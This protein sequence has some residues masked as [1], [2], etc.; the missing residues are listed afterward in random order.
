MF[1]IAVLVAFLSSLDTT[2]M[3]ML[4]SYL[5]VFTFVFVI[6]ICFLHRYGYCSF[7]RVVFIQGKGSYSK[8][9]AT[10]SFKTAMAEV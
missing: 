10:C 1:W 7:E 5:R 4:L 6:A 2:S 3:G 9:S 8:L